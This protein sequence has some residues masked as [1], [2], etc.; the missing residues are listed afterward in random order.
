MASHHAGPD[1]LSGGSVGPEGSALTVILYVLV[2]V[3]FHFTYRKAAV[4]PDPAGVKTPLPAAAAP[5][6]S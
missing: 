4:Y 2:V 5:E 3:L 1:W 6:I